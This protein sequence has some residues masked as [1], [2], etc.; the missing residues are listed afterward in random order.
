LKPTNLHKEAVFSTRYV[1]F[2]ESEV[3]LVKV[4]D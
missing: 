1:V 4:S 3:A 2:K